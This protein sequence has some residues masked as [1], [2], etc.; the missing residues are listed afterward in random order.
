LGENTLNGSIQIIGIGPGS[1]DCLTTGAG[2]ALAKVDIILGYHTY[3]QQIE[4][5]WP[6]IP[7]EGSAMRHEVKRAQRAV[8]LAGNGKK[9]AVVSG[10]D[11]GIYGMAGLIFEILEDFPEAHLIQVEVLPGITALTAAAALLGAP[12]MTDF[13]AISL[14]DYLIPLDTILNRLDAAIRGDFVICL[15]NPRS[16]QRTRPFD[17]ACKK[18]LDLCGE[19]RPVGVVQAAFRAEQQVYCTILKDLPSLQIGMDCIL[20]VGNTSTRILNGKI[21]TSRGYQIDHK[22]QAGK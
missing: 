11:A 16:H 20:I 9:V 4:S 6:D 2:R 21:V 22:G 1:P 19:N 10:G 7:R 14:S 3:L 18:L 13:A 15:Y 17:C 5:F 12:L 8:E